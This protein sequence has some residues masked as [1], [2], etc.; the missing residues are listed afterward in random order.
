MPWGDPACWLANGSVGKFCSICGVADAD[1]DSINRAAPGD[2]VWLSAPPKYVNVWLPGLDGARADIPCVEIGRRKSFPLPAM[3]DTVSIKGTELSFQW[4]YCVLAFAMTIHKI[5]GQT[6]DRVV[7]CLD[8]TQARMTYEQ[9]LVAITRVRRA[10]DLRV[11]P[12]LLGND[13]AFPHLHG[14]KQHDAVVR[15]F[16]GSFDT[17]GLRR[18]VPLLRNE[19]VPPRKTTTRVAKLGSEPNPAPKASAKRDPAPKASAKRDREPIS[20]GNRGGDAA[21]TVTAE[22][23][24]IE[25]RTPWAYTRS[26][27][28]DALMLDQLSGDLFVSGLFLRETV[29]QP[30]VARAGIAARRV[31]ATWLNY[32]Q[33]FIAVKVDLDM[34]TFSVRNSLRTHRPAEE[35]AEICRAKLL[36]EEAAASP[37]LTVVRQE[38]ECRQQVESECAVMT[39]ENLPHMMLGGALVE[40]TRDL[41]ATRYLEIYRSFD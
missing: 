38:H 18:Y 20:V 41:V 23:V 3:H 19:T 9:V 37:P 1:R 22:P 24:V 7:L 27:V 34:R 15:W 2:V 21:L 40:M 6:L 31:F 4:H 33:H 8:K 29:G 5:Q 10:D 12:A 17:D 32:G 36:V 13:P 28:I 26:E 35:L 30:N 11:L 39:I 25:I 14:L 16:D